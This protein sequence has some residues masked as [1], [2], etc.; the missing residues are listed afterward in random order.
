MCIVF[1]VMTLQIYKKYLSC[2]L[3]RTTSPRQRVYWV[4]F[5]KMRT[6]K[7]S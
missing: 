1:E 4:V 2:W 7:I 6:T 5:V 3:A